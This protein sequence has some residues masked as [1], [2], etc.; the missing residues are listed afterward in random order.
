MH[1]YP[2][3]HPGAQL[4]WSHYKLLSSVKDEKGE[5]LI[6]EGDGLKK[7]ACSLEIIE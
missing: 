2:I 5:R 6:F 7:P 3:G 4:D 1:S